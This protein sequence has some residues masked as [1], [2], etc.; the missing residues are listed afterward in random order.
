MVLQS[1]PI[2]NLLEKEI[3][4]SLEQNGFYKSILDSRALLKLYNNDNSIHNLV[5]EG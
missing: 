2:Y 5:Q 4:P 3:Q 1:S